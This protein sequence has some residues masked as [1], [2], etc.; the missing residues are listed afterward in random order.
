MHKQCCLK[1]QKDFKAI[2]CSMTTAYSDELL[3]ESKPWMRSLMCDVL[4]L[5]ASR[6]LSVS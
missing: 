5:S 3:D 4:R 2:R 1:K 6:L